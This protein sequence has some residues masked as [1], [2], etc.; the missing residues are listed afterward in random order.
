VG[1]NPARKRKD[2]QAAFVLKSLTVTVVADR[3]GISR[4][5]LSDILHGRRGMTDR[6]ARALSLSTGIP[7]ADVLPER[8]D[9]VI[10]AAAYRHCRNG[11]WMD[12]ANTYND[13]AGYTR[14]RRCRARRLAGRCATQKSGEKGRKR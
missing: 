10:V 8:E 1:T 2:L 3:V 9:P 4:G 11:H 13:R 12:T 7:L 6:L 5:H 14:C